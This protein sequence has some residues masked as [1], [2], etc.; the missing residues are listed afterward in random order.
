M[1]KLSRYLAVLCLLLLLITPALSFSGA[2]GGLSLWGTVVVP[3]LLPFMIC[4][5]AVMGLGGAEL[6]ARPFTPILG[7]FPGLSPSGSFALICGVLCGYPMGSKIDGEFLDSRQISANEAKALLAFCSYPSPMF[8]AG[9]TMDCLKKAEIDCP[10]PALLAA[11]YLPA[12]PLAFLARRRFLP[13]GRTFKTALAVQ[14]AKP[15]RPFSFDAHMMNS[16][17]IMIRIGG[18]IMFFSM[19]ATFLE[20]SFLPAGM[21]ALFSALMEMTTGIQAI[22]K[23]FPSWAVRP[24]AAATASFGGISGIFQ[25]KSVLK[26]PELSIRDYVQWKCLH[27]SLSAALMVLLQGMGAFS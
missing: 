4:T 26:N 7:R 19:A 13:S 2:L 16:F 15:Q 27:S 22:S 17:E 3:T 5:G 21:S 25:T 11:V 18:Y 1:K 24:L 20:R 14:E 12:L 6:L 8:L 9:Y 23:A 10:L